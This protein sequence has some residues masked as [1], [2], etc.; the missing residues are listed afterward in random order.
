MSGTPQ[1]ISVD[2]MPENLRRK[3]DALLEEDERLEAELLDP[4]ILVD[5]RAVAKRSMRRSA[6][7]SL[8]RDYRQW[9]KTITEMTELST[10][11][12]GDDAELAT[13]ARA[14]LKRLRV[15]AATLLD[16]IQSHLV[17]ADDRSI[18]AIILE[19]RAGVGGDEAALWAGDLVE[20]YR[21]Y[22]SRRR[23]SVEPMDLTP[24]EV[25]GV[26][27]CI[28]HIGGA[29]VWS[30][31]AF[32]SGT[33][34][35]KRVPATETQ[36]RIHTS[37]ATVAI[38]PEPEEVE[39]TI[40]PD[41]VKESITTAQ[42]PGG[43]N[44]NKVATAVHLIHKPTGIEVRMQETKSQSQNREKAW[45]LLR[46]RLYER[47]RAAAAAER[48]EL[49]NSLIGHAG[50]AEKIRTYR[51]K[52]G[53]VVDHRLGESMPLEKIMS[54]ELD[55]LITSLTRLEIAQRLAAL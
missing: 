17:T 7:E 27:A 37:T 11:V 5:H 36:G 30:E 55:D 50:R 33:H 16:E 42:G 2:A 25:G 53:I 19:I 47:E 15:D 8:A 18:G 13:I 32:E 52:E 41:D 22:A 46:A 44:V 40:D 51:A 26:K 35:V 54:G 14:E 38:L 49:R 10:L 6:I 45:Q 20:M 21:R 12:S 1:D 23:W 39:I 31:L 3:L 28:L 43:Q 34:Q 4:E 29:G 24:G 48:T 9:R